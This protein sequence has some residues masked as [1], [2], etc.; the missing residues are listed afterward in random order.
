MDRAREAADDALSAVRGEGREALEAPIDAARTAIAARVEK[1]RAEFEAMNKSYDAAA[2][3]MEMLDAQTRALDDA[4]SEAIHL[5]RQANAAA[6]A[7]PAPSYFN[8]TPPSAGPSLDALAACGQ[9]IDGARAQLAEA[10]Q[11]S[12][13]AL[14]ELVAEL[15]ETTKR[16]DAAGDA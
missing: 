7:T 14:E 6:R 15:D 11:Q 3:R 4:A 10:K 8:S 1:M 9:M 2:A 12:T 5:Y 16:L 13:R